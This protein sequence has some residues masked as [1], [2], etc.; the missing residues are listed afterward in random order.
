MLAVFLGVLVV[1]AYIN[2]EFSA[3]HVDSEVGDQSG[4]PIGIREGG[5]VINTTGGRISSSRTRSGVA[6]SAHRPSLRRYALASSP[7]ETTLN[8]F[9]IL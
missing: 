3:D 1:Q 9:A 6:T 4:V 8:R 7:L 2:S 5:P